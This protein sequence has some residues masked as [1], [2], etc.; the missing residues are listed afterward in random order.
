MST[1][2]NLDTLKEQLRQLTVI[3]ASQLVKDLEEEW[4]VTANAPVAVAAVAGG[5]VAEAVEEKTEFNVTLKAFSDKLKCIK[6]VREVTGLGLK[7]AKQ[8]VE[9]APKPLKESVKKEEA[10]EIKKKFDGIGE[11]VID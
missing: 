7:E 6:A 8:L 3:Q 4:G 5:A 10:E 2:L 9:E 1:E 11:V